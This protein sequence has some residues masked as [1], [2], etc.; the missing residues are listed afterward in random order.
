MVVLIGQ[1]AFDVVAATTSYPGFKA[2]NTSAYTAEADS[3]VEVE[4]RLAHCNVAS[5]WIANQVLGFGS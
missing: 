5:R 4:A 1:V 2:M 3:A